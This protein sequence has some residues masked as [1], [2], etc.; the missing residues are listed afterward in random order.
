MKC[1]ILAAG[2]D[3]NSIEKSPKCLRLINN[4]TIIDHFIDLFVDI[5]SSNINLVGGFEILQIMEKYPNLQYNYNSKWAETKSLYS[6][7]KVFATLTG[8]ILIAYS[9]IIHKREIFEFIDRDKINVFYDSLWINRY[10]NRDL[11]NLEK[12]FDNKGDL[13]GEFA[14]LMYVPSEKLDKIKFFTMELNDWHTNKKE[15]PQ[16]RNY[17]MFNLW[18]RVEIFSLLSLL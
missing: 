12:V 4:K 6:L 13:L 16:K 15:W 2:K 1:V 11:K 10:E 18:F 17:K 3:Q 8:Q 7:S 14:G 5:P 9:D